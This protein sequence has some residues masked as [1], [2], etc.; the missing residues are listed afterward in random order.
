[1]QFNNSSKYYITLQQSSLGMALH[2][3]CNITLHFATAK[4]IGYGTLSSPGKTV[5]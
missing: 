5:I 1:M 2:T 3:Q 4:L